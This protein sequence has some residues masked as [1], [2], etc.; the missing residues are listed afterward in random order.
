[1]FEFRNYVKNIINHTNYNYSKSY[2][3]DYDQIKLI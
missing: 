2:F 1:M 3:K